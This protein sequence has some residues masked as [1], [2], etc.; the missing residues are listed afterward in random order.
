MAPTEKTSFLTPYLNLLCCISCLFPS[1]FPYFCCMPLKSLASSFLSLLSMSGR[2]IDSSRISW[3][4]S[5]IFHPSFSPLNQLISHQSLYKGIMDDSV[6]GFADSKVGNLS[7]SPLTH[8]ASQRKLQRK[9][10]RRSCISR[11]WKIYTGHSQPPS[12][13]L[14]VQTV[15][16]RRI[17]SFTSLYLPPCTPW[18]W[19]QCLPLSDHG[20]PLLNTSLLTM[21]DSSFAATSVNIH[22]T[23]WWSPG[24]GHFQW[25]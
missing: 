25:A 19:M 14:C 5:A 4:L 6:K 22:R 2:Y 1:C 10:F 13:P 21:T 9:Q 3:V 15:V 16:S 17:C 23:L 11:P 12:W 8:T 24:L 7:C 20:E 18:G